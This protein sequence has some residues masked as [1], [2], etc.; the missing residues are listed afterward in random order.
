MLSENGD[1][2]Y[3]EPDRGSDVCENL[4]CLNPYIHRMWTEGAF[5]LRPLSQSEDARAI[6]VEWHWLPKIRHGPKDQ[7]S[8][9]VSPEST[10]GLHQSGEAHLCTRDG[11]FVHTGQHFTFTTPDPIT[12]PL[13]SFTLLDM[14]F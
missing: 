1:L 5:A 11:R 9:S 6:M 8:L 12:M 13:P 14:Q 2:L 4:L 7:V 3:V 10:E